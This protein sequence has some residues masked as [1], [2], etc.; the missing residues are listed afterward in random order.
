MDRDPQPG[1]VLQRATELTEVVNNA[2]EEVCNYHS[3]TSMQAARHL[4]LEKVTDTF[5]SSLILHCPPSLERS[6]AIAKAREAK[7]WA[8]ASIAVNEEG[9]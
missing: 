3:P 6:T 7:M 9:S 5:I 8:S 1:S 4:E 2:I